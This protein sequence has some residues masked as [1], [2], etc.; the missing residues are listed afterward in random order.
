MVDTV[1]SVSPLLYTMNRRMQVGNT[2]TEVLE[3]GLL[4]PT[5]ASHTDTSRPSYT[6]S[7]VGHRTE[8]RKMKSE[9]HYTVTHTQSIRKI[10]FLSV[11]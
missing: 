5:L 6:H 1:W 4:G 10:S 11:F 9:L 2:R 8:K 3:E 7:G